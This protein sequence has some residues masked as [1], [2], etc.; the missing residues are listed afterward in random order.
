MITIWM[1]IMWISNSVFPASIFLISTFVNF[2]KM[3]ING[4]RLFKKY[5]FSFIWFKFG[6][7]AAAFNVNPKAAVLTRKWDG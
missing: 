6:I 2:D 7:K 3:M 4:Q 1:K 5:S